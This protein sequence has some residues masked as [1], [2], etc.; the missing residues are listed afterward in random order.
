M[1]F[2]AILKDSLREAI[3]AK[4]FTVM[5]CLSGVVILLCA[6]V[7]FRQTTVEAELR[8]HTE[9]MTWAARQAMQNQPE[10]EGVPAA[11]A[12][13]PRAK[14]APKKLDPAL[15]P[16]Q[17]DI[18]DFEKLTGEPE[19]WLGRYRFVLRLKFADAGTVTAIRT[20]NVFPASGVAQLLRGRGGS[21]NW[22]E[23]IEAHDQPGDD[24]TVLAYRVTAATTVHDADHWPYVPVL[25]FGLLP[26]QSW[27]TPRAEQVGLVMNVLV[28]TVGAAVAM[29][30]S[31][32]IT[33]F[34]IPNMLRKGTV[35]LLI[36]KPIHRPTLLIYKYLGGLLFMLL[37]AAL[38]VAGVWL[39]AGLRSGYWV[40]SFLL[41][42]PLL[43]FEFAIYYSCSTLF[44][45]LTRSTIVSILMTSLLWFVLWLVGQL[46][47]WVELS[48]ITDAIPENQKPPAWLARGVDAAHFVLPRIKDLDILNSKIVSEG[49]P[50][51]DRAEREQFGKFL[52]S[53]KW[54]ETLTV[55]AAFIVVLLGLSCWR[56][57]TRD[58]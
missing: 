52:D 21:L 12:P 26:V 15:Q 13:R 33:A 38:I 8:R 39:V 41:S 37:N 30:L 35:D 19:P 49:L 20:F 45:V 22:L 40:N 5:V 2:F 46:Y 16:P 32:I 56:F 9:E 17:F 23:V 14:P 18:L 54:G 6:S 47:S 10:A 4:V 7:S 31:T 24:P 11:D 3:D 28:N 1:K 34:F 29:L 42:I 50:D 58:Y 44:G 57:A 48:R 36:V 43:T 25:F 51:S 55:S 53:F 27:A